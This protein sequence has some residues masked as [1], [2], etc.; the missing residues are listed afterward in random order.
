M[1]SDI[2]S[3]PTLP[4]RGSGQHPVV[5]LKSDWRDDLLSELDDELETK[6][7]LD[8][9]LRVDVRVSS[10][11]QVRPSEGI[12]K[13]KIGNKQDLD[14][15]LVEEDKDSQYGYDVPHC[16]KSDSGSLLFNL[17]EPD[18]AWLG[19]GLDGKGPDAVEV[20]INGEPV[21]ATERKQLGFDLLPNWI[22]IQ[23]MP[24]VSEV[25]YNVTMCKKNELEDVVLQQL[26]GVMLPTM[27]ERETGLFELLST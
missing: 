26:V 19:M 11:S 25:E 21:E 2:A 18:L 15:Y 22:R 23:T 20:M 13:L 3:C 10:L 24:P 9:L 7:L 27:S 1:Y 16:S 5:D 14:E 17:K 6:K 12:S 4:K 8:F